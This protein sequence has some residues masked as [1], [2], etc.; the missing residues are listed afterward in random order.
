MSTKCTRNS[1]KI[2]IFTAVT[3]H[4]YSNLSIKSAHWEITMPMN[5]EKCCSSSIKRKT[6]IQAPHKKKKI[7]KPRN[8]RA[9]F[10]SLLP[11]LKRKTP[12]CP[13]IRFLKR[14]S[15]ESFSGGKTKK[16]NRKK[17]PKWCVAEY[18]QK[19]RQTNNKEKRKKK[20][21]KQKSLLKTNF[22]TPSFS[23]SQTPSL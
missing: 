9:I 17:N 11:F 19:E 12:P 21:G 10:C 23:F 14:H 7:Q 18:L 20:G 22:Q 1:Q 13:K 3:T 4:V 16:K 15:P 2:S 8:G 6:Q 5:E